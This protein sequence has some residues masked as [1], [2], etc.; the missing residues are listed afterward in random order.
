MYIYIYTY[1]YLSL[2]FDV[3]MRICIITYIM[4]DYLLYI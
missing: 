4:N 3:Y 1:L 2:L